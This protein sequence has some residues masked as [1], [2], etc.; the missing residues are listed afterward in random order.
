MEEHLFKELFH[1]TRDVV[2]GDIRS[3]SM[4][5]ARAVKWKSM[6][7]KHFIHLPPDED[8]LRQHCLRVNYLVRHHSPEEPPFPSR[9]WLGVSK[10]S[11][12]SCS[13][14]TSFSPI[15]IP[16]PGQA[17]ED[18]RTSPKMTEN[19]SRRNQIILN[20]VWQKNLIQIDHISFIYIPIEFR[21][22]IAYCWL[23]NKL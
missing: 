12:W 11:M 10:W 3:I 14:H 18:E 22:F 21:N 2:Y 6:K 13:S 5:E 9:I 17:D 23:L 15:N 7:K 4:A 1:F 16:A 8:S 19:M 20:I